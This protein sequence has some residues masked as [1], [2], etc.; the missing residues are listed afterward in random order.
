MCLDKLE[1]FS[2]ICSDVDDDVFIHTVAF[3][4]VNFV[5]NHGFLA[6]AFQL[7]GQFIQQ[8]PLVHTCGRTSAKEQAIQRLSFDLAY[9]Q[10]E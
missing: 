8:S 1:I 9:G 3:I 4:H 2:V 6:V 5:T 10:Y 7:Q